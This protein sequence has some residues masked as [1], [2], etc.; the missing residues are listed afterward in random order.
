MNS[1]SGDVSKLY[2]I[3]PPIVAEASEIYTD[4]QIKDPTTTTFGR[5][6]SGTTSKA[7]GFAKIL[8]NSRVKPLKPLV[9]DMRVLKSEAEIAN[10]RKAGKASGRAF[11]DA[12]RQTWTREKDLAAFLDYH[13][14]ANG[15]DCSAYVPV[16]AGGKVSA[17]I[18]PYSMTF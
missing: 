11:T 15:C 5:F 9:N 12:M 17:F 14:K 7:E 10:M 3:L 13:F 2:K 8:E 6:L 18:V 4:I 1:Q 16:V